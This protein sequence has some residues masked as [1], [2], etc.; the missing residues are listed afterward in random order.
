MASL[1]M[2]S[3]LIKLF[4]NKLKSTTLLSIVLFTF[5][6]SFQCHR[7][8]CYIII[9]INAFVVAIIINFLIAYRENFIKLQQLVLIGGPDDGVVTPWQSRYL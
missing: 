3:L 2:M 5:Q 1:K 7:M 6:V 9:C 4:V 8:K